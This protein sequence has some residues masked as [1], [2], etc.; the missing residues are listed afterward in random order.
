MRN[1]FLL[2]IQGLRWSLSKWNKHFVRQTVKT[3]PQPFCLDTNDKK[4]DFSSKDNCRKP[5]QHLIKKYY[6]INITADPQLFHSCSPTDHQLIHSWSLDDP[7]LITN[8]SPADLKLIHSW[9][10]ADHQL[11]HS[12]SPADQ[13]LIKSWYTTDPKLMSKAT[14]DDLPM[15]WIWS[16]IDP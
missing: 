12:W 11:I 9:L 2:V 14:A 6:L 10:P 15:L 1:F 4:K 5:L 16:K 7:Q 13:K 3:L 8:W